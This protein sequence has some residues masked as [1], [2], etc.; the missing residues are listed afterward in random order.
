MK[1]GECSY[2]NIR[3]PHSAINLGGE[4]RTHF[5]V[6]VEANSEVKELIKTNILRSLFPEGVR[7]RSGIG[8]HPWES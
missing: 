1:V 7:Y 2:M 3:K 6:D 8:T 5:V 4:V